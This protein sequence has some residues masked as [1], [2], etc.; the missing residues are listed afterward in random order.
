MCTVSLKYGDTTDNYVQVKALQSFG[1]SS[2]FVQNANLDTIR[3]Q[4]DA[5]IPVPIGILHHGPASAPSGGGHWICVIGYDSTGFIVHDPWGEIDH[6]TGTYISE[7]GKA[8]T[9]Q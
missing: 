7:D 4:I 6:A 9:L 8:I 2:K 1:V 5:G 3:S